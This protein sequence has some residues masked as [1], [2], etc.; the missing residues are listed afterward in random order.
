MLFTLL[1]SRVVRP[2]TWFVLIISS[3]LLGALRRAGVDPALVVVALGAGDGAR[4]R[5]ADAC[6]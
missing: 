6:A 4:N 5:V 2:G 1:G 3:F